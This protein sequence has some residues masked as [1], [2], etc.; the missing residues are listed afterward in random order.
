M[1]VNQSN[2]AEIKNA[3]IETQQRIFCRII[4][5]DVDCGLIKEEQERTIVEQIEKKTQ[6]NFKEFYNRYKDS[7]GQD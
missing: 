4:K 2:D 5:H 1:E 3:V 6:T 7:L